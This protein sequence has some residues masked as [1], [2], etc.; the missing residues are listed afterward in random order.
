MSNNKNIIFIHI[1]KN[2]GTSV[3]WII[4]PQ[5]IDYK[6][7]NAFQIRDEIGVETF[8]A[9]VKF[10]IVRHPCDRLLSLYC[11]LSK[12]TPDSIDWAETSELRKILKYYNNFQDLVLNI[13]A[14]ML[15]EKFYIPQTN[16]VTIDGKIV[17]DFIL[18][19]ENIAVEWAAFA[20]HFGLYDCLPHVNKSDHPTWQKYYTPL[21]ITRMRALY[22]WN[23]EILGYTL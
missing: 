17:C 21:M 8:N 23:F 20:R 14:D 11:W 16:W 15:Y 7:K 10:S 6:H 1:P 2:A 4:C 9:A 5:Y 3:K 13:S 12:L 19:Y 18:K 22:G